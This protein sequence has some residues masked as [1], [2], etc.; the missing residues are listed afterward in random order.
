[1]MRR[2]RRRCEGSLLEGEEDE[3]MKE[4]ISTEKEWEKGCKSL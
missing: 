1:M 4:G 2:R 3:K